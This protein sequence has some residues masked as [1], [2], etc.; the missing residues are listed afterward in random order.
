M[1]ALSIERQLRRF[2][3]AVTACI[4]VGTVVELVLV[5]HTQ[6]TLQWIPFILSAIGSVCVAWTWFS[7]GRVSLI[8][9]RWVMAAIA[10]G[11]LLG[12]WLHFSG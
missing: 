4:F 2:L 1:V 11:S 6:E 9:L 10:L 5:E 12:I 3:L 8:V 7:P